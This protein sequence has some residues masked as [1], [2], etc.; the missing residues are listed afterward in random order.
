MGFFESYNVGRRQGM[1]GVL[2]VREAEEKE[3]PKRRIKPV[4]WRKRLSNR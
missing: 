3:K 1:T 2:A 4:P